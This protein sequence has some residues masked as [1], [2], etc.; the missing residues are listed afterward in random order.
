LH[1][2]ISGGTGDAKPQRHLIPAGLRLDF[3]GM[4]NAEFLFASTLVFPTGSAATAEIT[5]DRV[6]PASGRNDEH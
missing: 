5:A 1:L 6:T 2:P 4:K 3:A